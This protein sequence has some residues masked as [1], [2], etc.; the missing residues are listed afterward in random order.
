[1]ESRTNNILVPLDFSEQSLIALEQ[2]YNIATVFNSELTIL[3][4]IT[5]STPI[6]SLFT[7]G[8][9]RD[10]ESKLKSKLQNLADEIIANT[11]LKVTVL[12][13][14]GKVVDTILHVA[15]NI[16]AMFIVL[17][18]TK[19]TEL[20]SKLLGTFATRIIREAKCPV[21]TIKGR[22][23][24]SGCDHILL[25][26]DLTH[27]TTQ[28]VGLA[29]WLGTHFKSVIHAVTVINTKDSSS[30]EKYADQ[31]LSVQR[32]IEAANIKCE[33]KIIELNGGGKEKYTEALLNYGAAIKAGLVMIMTQKE[34]D[35]KKFFI[36]SL[37]TEIMSES[38]I[39]VMSCIPKH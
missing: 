35:V 11:G 24:L 4:V 10:I 32:E 22:E 5:T 9:K 14:K 8:E 18:V 28:K 33:T 37:A 16:N 29:I 19:A 6:W 12:I 25:P 36:G 17:G 7:D 21:I 31:L 1:M 38:E 20:K 3:N 23:H 34:S 13:E 15:D 30:K 39:P 26:L 2:A 27:V